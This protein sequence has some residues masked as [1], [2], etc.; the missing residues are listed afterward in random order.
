MAIAFLGHHCVVILLWLFA[1]SNGDSKNMI[2]VGL[3]I[4]VVIAM[5]LI[6]L[7]AMTA[8]IRRRTTG[9]LNVRSVTISGAVNIVQVRAPYRQKFFLGFKIIFS[10]F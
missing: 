1:E 6:S 5:I 3:M 9:L 4:L 7:M 8:L 2:I 10:R